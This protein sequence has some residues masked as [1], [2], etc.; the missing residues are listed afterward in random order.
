M[1][2]K[3]T[4]WGDFKLT[5]LARDERGKSSEPKEFDLTVEPPKIRFTKPVDNPTLNLGPSAQVNYRITTA[6]GWTPID[7]IE[8][9][10]GE[11]KSGLEVVG[12]SGSFYL[13]GT[14]ATYGEYVIQF[15]AYDGKQNASAPETMT[16]AVAAAP[17]EFDG[18]LEY[19]ARANTEFGHQIATSK[20]WGER[21]VTT[22]SKLPEG[23]KF[24]NGKISGTPTKGG[25]F[26][27]RVICTDSKGKT[28]PAN[29]KLI[30]AHPPLSIDVGSCQV[31]DGRVNEPYNASFV[32]SGGT[33]AGFNITVNGELPCRVK[34]RAMTLSGTPS[35]K[36]EFTITVIATD[37][38]KNNSK[39]AEFKFK[40]LDHISI[41][42]DPDLGSVAVDEQF[43]K[44]FAAKDGRQPVK[45]FAIVSE[46][47]R[48]TGLAF[49]GSTLKGTVPQ[50]GEYTITV[51]AV[52][53]DDRESK[54]VACKLLVTPRPPGITTATLAQGVV[55]TEY[56]QSIVTADGWGTST[57]AMS[58]A[59]AGFRIEGDAIEGNSGDPLEKT[60]QITAT[61]EKGV[62]SEPKEYQLV[63]A[64]KP[65]RILTTTL[66]DAKQDNAYTADINV[67][68]GW[69][70]VAIEFAAQAPAD[71]ACAGLQ[72]TGTPK[73]SA[74]LTIS[75]RARDAKGNVSPSV[76]L[77]LDIYYR[78]WGMGYP[79][80]E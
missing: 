46:T 28:K 14:P 19:R 48:A 36:G 29:F 72:I 25:D 68:G 52:D 71:F 54:P 18:V 67:E 63:I 47:P 35:A 2:G 57:L 50:Y 59:V 65:V 32:C 58:P 11:K 22:S 31:P 56:N 43:T 21:T 69:A 17:P 64:P 33:E 39:P 70:P 41:T 13:K 34:K 77:A 74:K 30:I 61:D 76:N 80:K 53:Q 45:S 42:T 78:W 66:A 5:V 40:I 79:P 16:L 27:L 12:D 51:K 75:L 73:Q 20:G 37:N 55:E 10:E 26:N 8:C 9:I 15:I 7:R 1:Q 62:K 6:D 24:D 4:G 49:E 23:V 38:A 3:A 60:I 44:A